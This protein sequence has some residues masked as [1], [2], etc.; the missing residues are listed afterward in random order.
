MLLHYLRHVAFMQ[1]VNYWKHFH[2]LWI[3]DFYIMSS[4]CTFVHVFHMYVGGP[5][6]LSDQRELHRHRKCNVHTG[7]NPVRAGL[8]V[9]S[10]WTKY[11]KI[12]MSI[13]LSNFRLF[14][15]NTSLCFTVFLSLFFCLDF[16]SLF[17]CS[18]LCIL[19]L[20]LYMSAL[21]MNKAVLSLCYC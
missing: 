17:C 11:I 8:W 21:F 3:F 6:L 2:H 15:C 18:Y 19:E 7:L 1:V 14:V 4:I 13:L 16:P 5:W 9:H 12:R 10:T 20:F